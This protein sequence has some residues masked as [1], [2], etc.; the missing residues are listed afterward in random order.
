VT[1]PL[2]LSLGTAR[3]LWKVSAFTKCQNLACHKLGRRFGSVRC[4]I[5]GRRPDTY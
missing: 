3:R 4:N 5:G 1:V 2:E